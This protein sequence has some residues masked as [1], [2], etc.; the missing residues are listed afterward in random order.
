MNYKEIRIRNNK[1][2][3]YYD[4]DKNLMPCRASLFFDDGWQYLCKMTNVSRIYFWRH[5]FPKQLN[6]GL[7]IT[8]G[9]RFHFIPQKALHNTPNLLNAVDVRALCWALPPIY[10]IIF[11]KALNISTSV[12]RVIVLIQSV[13]I[14]DV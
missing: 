4:K 11:E 6:T 10:I 12:F 3:K 8:K 14:W 1:N 13:C 7:Q 2:D 5:S 9:L